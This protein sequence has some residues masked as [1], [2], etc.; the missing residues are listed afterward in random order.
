MGI[1]AMLVVDEQRKGEEQ[2]STGSQQQKNAT[3]HAVCQCE[4][5]HHCYTGTV[6]GALPIVH[7]R[8][9]SFILYSGKS[10]A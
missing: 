1:L 10:S 2:H 7:V 5:G 3:E 4:V 9:P 6:L 8:F